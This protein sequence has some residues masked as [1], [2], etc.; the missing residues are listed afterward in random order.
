MPEPGNNGQDFGRFLAQLIGLGLIGLVL[1]FA[2]TQALE[3]LLR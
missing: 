2:A 3:A 1:W